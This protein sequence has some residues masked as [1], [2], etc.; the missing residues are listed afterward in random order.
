MDFFVVFELYLKKLG[1]K[2]WKSTDRIIHMS[3][4]FRNDYDANK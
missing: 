4:D 2:T 3:K 1:E